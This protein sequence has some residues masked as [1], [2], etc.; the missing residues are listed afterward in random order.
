MKYAVIGTGKTGQAI[1]DLLP[2]PD[3]V[4][5]FNSR[6]PVTVEK[7]RQAD[8]GIVFVPG[9]ALGE[10]LPLLLEAKMPLVIG[11]TG[12]AWPVDLDAK[13]RAMNM[14]WI[15]GQNFSVGLNVMRYFSERIK[16]SL[17]ALKPKQAQLSIVEKH[18]IHKVDAPSGTA[19][20]IARALD[21]PPENI[22]SIREG[23]VKGT[24]TV[25]FD[26]PHDR[27]SVT[28][29]ALDRAAFAEG[30]VLACNQIHKLTAGLHDFEKLADDMIRNAVKG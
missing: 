8:V 11:T 25:S 24:H 15:I 5:V 21:V 16:Q 7:L 26:W 18:H 22:A 9:K 12:Y 28:H 6:N 14:P 27:I 17:N 23:D 19:I 1:L 30:V 29:E 2:A 10:M 13:L 3:V 4:A 20:Y